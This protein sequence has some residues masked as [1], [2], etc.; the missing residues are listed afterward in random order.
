M[1]MIHTELEYKRTRPLKTQNDLPISS[2]FN[3]ET[4]L[5]YRLARLAFG[6]KRTSP[7]TKKVVPL[8][9]E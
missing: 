5:S 8:N 9:K 2:T 7:P 4:F 1:I 3:S 6:N